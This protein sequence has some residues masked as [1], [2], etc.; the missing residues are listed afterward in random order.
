MPSAKTIRAGQV[1]DAGWPLDRWP[2]NSRS[3]CGLNWRRKRDS[4]PRTSFPVNG[5]QDRRLK[6][7]GHSS[8]DQRSGFRR[9][10]QSLRACE[11]LGQPGARGEN[12]WSGSKSAASSR[13]ELVQLFQ[14]PA[15]VLRDHRI[16]MAG[17]PSQGLFELVQATIPHRH[18]DVAEKSGIFG[19]RDWT[20]CEVQTEFLRRER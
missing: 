14:G 18:G 12:R 9:F 19:S 16:W 2:Y 7:L 8:T 4:N 17:H 13:W 6:P 11:A 1:A 5:F 20:R 15:S 10:T 3:L